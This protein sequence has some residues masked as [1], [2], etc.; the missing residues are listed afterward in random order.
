MTVS[1]QTLGSQKA[2][3]F[4]ALMLALCMFTTGGAGLVVQYVVATATTNIIGS[5]I[6]TFSITIGLMMGAMGVAGLFQERM[7][8]GNLLMKFFFI[9]VTLALVGGFA[10]LVLYYSYGTFFEHFDFILYFWTFSIGFLIGL[11]IPV[12]M[13]FIEEQG[14]GLKLNLKYVFAADYIGAAVFAFVWVYVLLQRFPITEI[15]FIVSG[16]NFAVALLTIYYFDRLG[17]FQNR[18]F[19]YTVSAG[20]I[21]LSLY[22]YTNNRDWLIPLQ[23]KFYDDPI[24]YETTTRYQ[25]LVVTKNDNRCTSGADDIRLYING[26]TQFGSCDEHI[27]HDNLVLP[28][29]HLAERT[30]S[31]LVLGGGDGLA[32]R[33]ILRHQ[34]KK[35]T[36]VD[37]DPAMVDIA[38]KNEFLLSLNEGSFLDSR[39]IT[40]DSPSIEDDGGMWQE[41]VMGND[42]TD[43]E[44]G[45][46]ET[47]MV[48]VV[49]RMH[50]DA[51]KFLEF[52]KETFDVIIVDLPDPSTVELSKL[53]SREFYID[54][55][56]RLRPGGVVV[57]QSTSPIH[58]REVF[59]EIG[60]TMKAAGISSIPYHD[61]VPS[62]GEWGFWIGCATYNCGA[63]MEEQIGE[64][65]TFKVKG[66]YL[67]PDRFRA[68]LEFG[69]V[70]GVPFADS[71]TGDNINSM[72][73]PT[74][75]LRYEKA[76]QSY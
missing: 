40:F 9:E 42:R 28:A 74:L 48:A 32:L 72:L 25:H 41:V 65:D 66:S 67:T 8:D 7:S 50:I 54:L 2:R 17:G 16:L 14:I 5:S 10:P 69:L 52:T 56:R 73:D 76:W 6:T 38:S 26:N 35:V 24:V 39:V 45:L 53:Y 20:A 3:A 61:N 63:Q 64:L 60:R 49:R 33:D 12:V 47:E 43:A 15:S 70:D 29:M 46:E 55:R 23:Q 18:W 59:L 58:A 4:G 71:A 22:G 68:N 34:T 62:F 57:V 44:T 13:R 36:L 51:G 75:F 19:V 27:Y 21:A 30:D 1:N 11:E 31:V 37:L